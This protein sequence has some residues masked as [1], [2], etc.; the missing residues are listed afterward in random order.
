MGI[1]F[2]IVVFIVLRDILHIL[3]LHFFAD[4]M[5]M[6][7]SVQNIPAELEASLK[8][9]EEY[10]KELRK[11][12]EAKLGSVVLLELIFKFDQAS[13]HTCFNFVD[14]EGSR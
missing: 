10:Q 1:I 13:S 14:E 3:I 9:L 12:R 5:P 7:D 2:S 11:E 6:V 4:I 8:R